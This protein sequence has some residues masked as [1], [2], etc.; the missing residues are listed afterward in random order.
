VSLDQALLLLEQGRAR[1]VRAP[2]RTSGLLLDP[3][4]QSAGVPVQLRHLGLPRRLME[5]LN[6][7]PAPFDT[8]DLAAVTV[9]A[10]HRDL[11]SWAHELLASARIVFEP[12]AGS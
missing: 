2:L 4:W 7:A 1:A 11:L 8:A 3:A 5:A 10:A 6:R 9:P 12:P